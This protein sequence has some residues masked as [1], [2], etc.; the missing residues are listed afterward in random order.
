MIG[1]ASISANAKIPVS[2]EKISS[3]SAVNWSSHWAHSDLFLFFASDNTDILNKVSGG[4]LPNQVTGATDYL[5]VT[6][7]GLNAR[8][9]T[10]D[11][12][13]YRTADSDYCFW[14]TDASESICDGNR[15]IGYDFPRILVKYLNVA[16]YTILWIGILKPASSVTNAMRDSF[17]L[18]VWWNNVLSHGNGKANRGTGQSVWTPESVYD[19]RAAE[20]FANM[21]AVGEPQTDARKTAINNTIVA[22]KAAGL[23][24]TRF[25]GFGLTRGSG[26]ASTKMNWIKDAHNLT[27]GGVGTLTYTEDVGYHSNGTTTYLDMNFDFT[28]GVHYTQ[29]SA[30]F[31]FKISGTIGGTEL[32]GVRDTANGYR[33]TIGKVAASGYNC[34]NEIFAG[35]AGPIQQIGY[36]GIARQDALNVHNYRNADADVAYIAT[37]FSVGNDHFYL[38]ALN[39]QSVAAFFAPT[40]E[41]IEFWFVGAYITRAE[42][43]TM[44]GIIDTNYIAA[45]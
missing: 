42:F 44:S 21:A 33:T 17:D 5:T 14:K 40:T 20:L 26:L 8:Y 15:L 10:P 22:L 6:G 34:V 41:E 3:P 4:Q 39:N 35:A 43:I 29:N 38:L 1:R 12:A 27:K 28:Q 16:P 11:N 13:T 25:D 31:G 19:A 45:L 30:S 7:S 36:N 23:F 9:R 37:S 18:S 2:A 24:D 32:H